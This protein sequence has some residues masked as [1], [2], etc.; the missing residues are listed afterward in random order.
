MNF[1]DATIQLKAGNKIT[2]NDWKG[3]YLMIKDNQL[4]SF[5]PLISKY[6]YDNNIIISD[7]WRVNNEPHDFNFSDIIPFLLKGKKAYRKDWDD[8]FIYFEPIMKELVV[9]YI[10]EST[11][12]P[13]FECFYKQDWVILNEG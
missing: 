5:M 1:N 8:T 4:K 9:S 12:V 11:F 2:R 3:I 6:Q 13:Q 7:N 10:D